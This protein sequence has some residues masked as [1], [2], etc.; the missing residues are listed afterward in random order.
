MGKIIL[1]DEM[2]A[3]FAQANGKQELLDEWG[4]HRR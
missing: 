2:R 3:K 4:T 1:T